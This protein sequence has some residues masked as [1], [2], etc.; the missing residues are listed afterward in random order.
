MTIVKCRLFL[1]LFLFF[2]CVALNGQTSSDSCYKAMPFCGKKI[3]IPRVIGGIVYCEPCANYGCVS[4][5]LTQFTWIYFKALTSGPVSLR[6]SKDWNQHTCTLYI[7]WGGFNSQDNVCTCGLTE[8]KILFC[9]T[10]EYVPHEKIINV[11]ADNYYYM[12]IITPYIGS[13]NPYYTIFMEQGNLTTPGHATLDCSL[14]FNQPCRFNYLVADTTTCDPIKGTFSIQGV[15][16]SQYAPDTGWLIIEDQTTGLRDSI[17]PPFDGIA[18][19]RIEEIPCDGV[20][21]F[22]KG[23]FTDGTC[24]INDTVSAPK[25]F[26]AVG[27]ISGGGHYCM[28]NGSPPQVAISIASGVPP[29]SFSWGVNGNPTGTII[30]YSGSWPYQFEA[31]LQGIYSLLYVSGSDGPG[32]YY[33]TAQVTSSVSPQPV[34]SDISTCQGVA[35]TL[36]PGSGYASYLWSNGST[37]P[38]ITVASAGIYTVTVTDGQGCTGSVSAE[39]TNLPHPPAKLIKHQ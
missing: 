13:W 7:I 31:T 23:W 24:E 35:V 4:A 22:I 33:G 21:H 5:A 14:V 19:Y 20:K 17:P 1:A 15:I 2:F 10:F 6:F 28:P 3:A 11:V 37:S 30:N 8:D 26:H 34:L 27:N 16:A 36:D 38:T 25:G 39:V 9:T 32:T 18:N 12:Y 29:Y